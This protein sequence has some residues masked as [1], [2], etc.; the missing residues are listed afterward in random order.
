MKKLIDFLLAI[1]MKKKLIM[2]YGFVTALIFGILAVI[3][4]NFLH[5]KNQYDTIN[6]ISDEIQLISQ[7]KG[8]INGVR[9]AFLLMSLTKNQDVKKIQEDVLTI[10]I[11]RIDENLARLKRGHYKGKMEEIEKV[12]VPFKET[13]L[14]EMLPL[15]KA[16][17]IDEMIGVLGKVQAPRA[18]V[19]LKVAN[20]VIENS[21]QDFV[22]RME[23][24]NSNI[25]S[26]MIT[27][28]TFVVVIF[29]ITFAFS[30]WFINRYIIGVLQDI[31]SSA[32]KVATGDL[33]VKVEA[34]TGDEFGILAID[35]GK[36]IKTMQSVM[37]DIANKTVYI[38]K[39]ATSLSVSGK[40]VSYR[41]DRDLERTTSAA[42]ATE[43]MSSTVG[44]IARNINM[45]FQAT[46]R[47]S[48]ASSEGKAMIGETVSSIEDVNMQIE[49]ASVRVND[50]AMLSRK[51]DEIVIMI[52]DIADQT[53]LL[54]L[55]AAIEAARAGEQ[56]RGF[57]VVADEVRKL[58]QKTTNATSEINNILGSIHTGTVSATDM[59][60]SAVKKAKVTGELALRLDQSFREIHENFEKVFDTV[61]Q[62][63]A[64]TEEQSSTAVEISSALSGI[65]EDARDNSKT[66][67]DMALSFNKFSEDAKDF[68]KILDGFSDPKMRVGVLKADYILWFHRIIDLLDTREV[69]VSTDE[70]NADRSRM[71]LW[72]YRDGK[73][74]FGNLGAFKELDTPHRRLHD[75]GLKAY[76]AAKNGDK[77]TVKQY[78]TEASGL[79]DTIISILDRLESAV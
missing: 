1:S 24:I 37:R 25:K 68:L 79:V 52:K 7:L 73:E 2:G 8:D 16:D 35:V 15:I 45:A 33:T 55:N 76:E 21:R 29:S 32:E 4:V 38:L 58:A 27:V 44:D 59:M 70:L 54:A 64:A 14:N 31:T 17:R 50:L 11:K 20:E 72:Y 5:I 71:G 69:T 53:N 3:A 77:E 10:H 9:A 60:D 22:G 65:V 13:L 74:M 19:F 46:E 51:I 49:K 57:A 18:N 61:H 75:L 78:V 48:K 26:T 56:G 47:A 36:I 28:V 12:L 63:V 62:V 23:T 67:K 6:E 39:D 41:V 43:E 30:F 40:E 42:A 34:K 66:V